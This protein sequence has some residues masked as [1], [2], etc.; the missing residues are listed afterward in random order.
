MDEIKYGVGSFL[1]RNIKNI[2]RPLVITNNE[3][4]EFWNYNP[5][6]KCF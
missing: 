6:D 2:F 1:D 4:K 5:M 3:F